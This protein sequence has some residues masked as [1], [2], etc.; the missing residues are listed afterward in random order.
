MDNTLLRSMTR[1]HRLHHEPERHAVRPRHFLGEV[2]DA[3]DFV[4]LVRFQLFPRDFLQVAVGQH[5]HSA[6]H[7]NGRRGKCGK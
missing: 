7:T 5:D 1:T 3:D 4:C 2:E 6:R